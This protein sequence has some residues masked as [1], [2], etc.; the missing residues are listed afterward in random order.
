MS[1][2]TELKK[3]TIADQLAQFE[4]TLNE[5]ESK[6]DLIFPKCQPAIIDK[7]IN[8]SQEEINV[9]SAEDCGLH[10]H[11]LAQYILYLQKDIN[12]NSVRINWAKNR[13]NRLLG[14]V[15]D[16]Y[17]DK[18]TK[19][20]VKLGALCSDNSEAAALNNVI[21]HAESRI[22][23]LTNVTMHISLI[24][25]TLSNLQTTKRQNKYESNRFN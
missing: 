21:L 16:Q 13:L 24:C 2:Q 15:N 12:R 14:T 1:G 9:M 10:A 8:L 22:L 19:Y 23:S 5:Y 3:H 11:T 6:I 17:G 20:E 4:A 25:N 7:A 18:W